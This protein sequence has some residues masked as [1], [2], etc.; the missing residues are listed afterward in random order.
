M[1]AA[2]DHKGI[3]ISVYRNGG[4]DATA[5]GVSSKADR[6]TV[7]GVE[8]SLGQFFPMPRG[9]QV[10]APSEDAPAVVV[11]VRNVGGPVLSVVPA[12]YDEQRQTYKAHPGVMAG[13]N[14]AATSDSRVGELVRTVTGHDFYG[15][16][17]VHDRIECRS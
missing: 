3:T 12:T 6:L 5:G 15:A 9:S 16:M 13:G 2:I 4:Y 10:F 1:N 11:K 7:V 14:Y 8:D 17:A